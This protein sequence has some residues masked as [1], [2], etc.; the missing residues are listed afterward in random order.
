MATVVSVKDTI[1]SVTV[2][3]YIRNHVEKEYNMKEKIIDD[4]KEICCEFYGYYSEPII[5]K[6]KKIKIE[7]KYDMITV[8]LNANFYNDW[9]KGF[10]ANILDL[11]KDGVYEWRFKIDKIDGCGLIIGIYDKDDNKSCCW[12]QMQ[13]RIWS[14][15]ENMTV[16]Y[17][18]I[19]NGDI[20]KMELHF[21]DTN[22]SFI[23]YYQN[24][25]DYSDKIFINDINRDNQSKQYCVYFEIC[26]ANNYFSLLSFQ[27][28]TN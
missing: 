26:T 28:V 24:D 27:R 19:Q 20:L 17:G 1:R 13:G 7:N 21:H 4:I 2:Y 16:G 11:S 12:M 3:G 15:S 10:G 14:K 25:E 6:N 23:K 22:K 18:N 5:S 8:T 9:A